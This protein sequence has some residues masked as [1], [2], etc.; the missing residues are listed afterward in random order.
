MVSQARPRIAE[1]SSMCFSSN[2]ITAFKYM[3]TPHPK[4]WY[5]E[6]SALKICKSDFESSPPRFDEKNHKASA[7][8]LILAETEV[9]ETRELF[10]RAFNWIYLVKSRCHK[11]CHN[12]LQWLHYVSRFVKFVIEK[13]VDRF[14]CSLQGLIKGNIGGTIGIFGL[15]FLPKPRKFSFLF[16][17]DSCFFQGILKHL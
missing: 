12:H 5:M 8:E 11:T 10:A 17:G 7:R 2:V 13:F 4:A 14:P 3:I 15:L 1:A 6:F 9:N 16:R